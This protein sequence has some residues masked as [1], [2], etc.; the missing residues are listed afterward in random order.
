MSTYDL[1]I[2]AGTVIDGTGAPG[3]IADVGI[4]GDRVVA[5]E[6]S[7]AGTAERRSMPPVGW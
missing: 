5:V 3:F 7:L 4:V 2:R 6:P 1:I